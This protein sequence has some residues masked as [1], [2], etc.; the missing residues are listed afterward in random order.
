MLRFNTILLLEG[1]NVLVRTWK[2]LLVLALFS[3]QA[4]EAILPST[5]HVCCEALQNVQLSHTRIIERCLTSIS[6]SNPSPLA[7]LSLPPGALP[8]VNV[9]L[10]GVLFWIALDDPCYR[11]HKAALV[12]PPAQK[13]TLPVLLIVFVTVSFLRLH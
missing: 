6:I 12:S 9:T 1:T 7:S 4:L 11:L 3:P 13:Q 5:P 8:A 10:S 2:T